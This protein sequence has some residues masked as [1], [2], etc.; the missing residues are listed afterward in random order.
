MSPGFHP[1][2]LSNLSTPTVP[3]SGWC[4]SDFLLGAGM[5]I[6]QQTTHKVVVI[7]E[8][9]K[10]HWFLPR[11]RKDIGESLEHAALR[12]AYEESGYRV[13]SLPLYTFTQA[14]SS[15]HDGD[16]RLQPNTEPVYMTVV[17]YGPRIRHGQVVRDAGEYVTSWYVGQIPDGA[18]REIGTGM[19]NEREYVAHLVSVQEALQLL[20]PSEARVLHYAW[21]V[22]EHTWR[23]Q[24]E[25]EAKGAQASS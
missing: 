13:E 20:H 8:P 7:N 6:V 14:P 23:V 2:A 10:Q 9:E 22:C 1:T 21:T 5:V 3:D 16:A 15:R 11:G 24:R 12:E 19:P 4:A 17:S 25:Q 18:V